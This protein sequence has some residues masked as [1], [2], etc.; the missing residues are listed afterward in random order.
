[1]ATTAFLHLV[2][3][4]VHGSATARMQGAFPREI[5]ATSPRMVIGEWAMARL[6]MS[7]SL[8]PRQLRLLLPTRRCGPDRVSRALRLIAPLTVVRLS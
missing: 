4:L 2:D 6:Q 3:L 5:S 1:M 8:G 7:P